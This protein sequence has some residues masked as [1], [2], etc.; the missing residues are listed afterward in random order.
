[1]TSDDAA[2]SVDPV[3]LVP[4]RG[5]CILPSDHNHILRSRVYNTS[6]VLTDGSANTAG[7]HDDIGTADDIRQHPLLIPNNGTDT[8]LACYKSLLQR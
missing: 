6:A 3:H 1:M 8:R 7:A 2:D 4:L 5:Q